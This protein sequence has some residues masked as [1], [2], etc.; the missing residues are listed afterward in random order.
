MDVLADTPLPRSAS[1]R[2]DPAACHE[3]THAMPAPLDMS[4]QPC[5]YCEEGLTHEQRLDAV[6]IDR[7]HMFSTRSWVVL[8]IVA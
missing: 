6:N 4:R 3:E 7:A 8:L 1:R 5:L 2:S